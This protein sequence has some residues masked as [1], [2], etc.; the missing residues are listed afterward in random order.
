MKAMKRWL[1]LIL[2]VSL[3]LILLAGCEQLTGGG[4]GGDDENLIDSEDNPSGD[5]FSSS[6]TNVQSPQSK[7]EAISTLFAAL[8]SGAMLGE[9]TDY[10]PPQNNYEVDELDVDTG[11]TEGSFQIS[12]SDETVAFSGNGTSYGE[13]TYDAEANA[14]ITVTYATKGT[15]SDEQDVIDTA[16]IIASASAVAEITEALKPPE[17]PY[18]F[19][20]GKAAF[21]VD[22]SADVDVTY[23]DN[24]G[25]DGTF[26]PT[27]I[28][29][30]DYSANVL[31]R[32]AISVTNTQGTT[33]TGD[34]VTNNLLAS[35]EMNS[36][37][38][39]SVAFSDD[40]A[41]IEDELQNEIESDV[42]V[43]IAAYDADG[44]QAESWDYGW[45][46]VANLLENM[47]SGGSGSTSSAA[48]AI[49]ML[50]SLAFSR[51]VGSDGTLPLQ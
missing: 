1:L 46:E 16:E 2:V 10:E 22:A 11:D 21:G 18:E 51:M 19:P 7:D 17:A 39:F 12:V 41:T 31:F 20:G 36:S 24:P 40:V 42:S 43:S 5:D 6:A 48:E 33:D 29:L 14:Q 50:E 45:D 35:I 23:E 26:T 38:S 3:G 47:E 49:D 25:S 8:G 15:G 28:E 37:G 32:V 9:S 30:S 34:D 13:I 4:G 44:N 27:S